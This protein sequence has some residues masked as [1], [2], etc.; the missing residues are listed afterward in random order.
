MLTNIKL[1]LEAIYLMCGIFAL[2]AGCSFSARAL[3]E[4]FD[5]GA[6]R[7]PDDGTSLVCIESSDYDSHYDAETLDAMT[8]LGFHRLAINGLSDDAAQP[9]TI[10]RYT[11]ICNGE[12]Y[13]HGALANVFN[14]PCTTGSDCEVIIH[15]CRRFG[16]ERTLD[17][18]H[19]VYAFVLYERP[20]APTM[21]EKIYIARDRYGVRP[22]YEIIN[23][24]GTII[25]V[26]SEGKSLQPLIG[27]DSTASLT[28]RQYQPGSYTVLKRVSSP[29][30]VLQDSE[31]GDSWCQEAPVYRP[32]SRTVRWKPT[33]A[34]PEG[35]IQPLG[36]PGESS[37]F[38][39]LHRVADA[40]SKAVACRVVNCERPI[41]CLLSG[42][43]DSSLIA[44]LAARHIPGKLETFSIGIEG[45]E[46]LA[47]AREV[48]AHIGSN[49]NEVVITE[50]KMLD[51]IPTVVRAVESYDTTTIR[52]S[53]PNFLLARH[54]S[55][56]SDAKVVFNGD[57]SDEVAGGYIYML[58]AP[59][60]YEFDQECHRLLDNIHFYDGLRSDRAISSH[61]LEAR[62]PFLDTE[63]VNTYMS[64][65]PYI[66]NPADPRNPLARL[67]GKSGSRSDSCALPMEK[68][69]LRSA[70]HF[71]FPDL[72][73]D[74]VL[75][76][77]KEA[78]SDGVS[79]KESWFQTISNHLSNYVLRGDAATM[80]NPPSTKEQQFYRDI[81]DAQYPNAA[82]PIPKFWMP[83][84]V[85][86]ADA[87]ARTLEIYG[88][89]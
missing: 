65:P 61:G 86:A 87:S 10:G 7:G 34:Q 30:R 26:A 64:V 68:L 63:F 32:F 28:I 58:M 75:W 49:H 17:L 80:A 20:E 41:A 9:M 60:S 36:P 57:G 89:D 84:Y 44:A 72:L 45:S 15:L 78:F 59:D 77:R 79:G 52:A 76:R 35:I 39:F 50:S 16:I 67:Y 74:S 40:L 54:I 82:P 88:E 27:A 29:S 21:Q 48:A 33:W 85:E 18:L 3:E 4:G 53:T 31:R 13:N 66:R 69:F 2:F 23:G 73:P 42:G 56:N 37:V 62:T 38:P 14:L 51:A 83:K 43:L 47:K 1:K 5:K 55:Q 22:L 25:G 46:D 81:F 8:W 24:A 6:P 11:L 12:I 71:A 70:V 19:G